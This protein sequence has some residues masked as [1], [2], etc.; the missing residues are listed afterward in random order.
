MSISTIALLQE[1]MT[2]DGIVAPVYSGKR[3]H[4][5]GFGQKFFR[6]LLELEGGVGA[7]HL[8]QESGS[9][10]VTVEVTD[11]GVLK[12]V[13]TPDDLAMV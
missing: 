2:P 7:R 12:D 1:T 5:V 4:P 9:S 6:G 13:D 8:L 10:V 11:K 3:G